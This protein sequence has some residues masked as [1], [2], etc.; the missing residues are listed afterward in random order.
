MVVMDRLLHTYLNYVRMYL[1]DL[2]QQ[3]TFLNTRTLPNIKMLTHDFSDF[4]L[5][6]RYLKAQKMDGNYLLEL[7][8]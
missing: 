7:S 3:I 6:F 5:E 4:S 1:T 2:T 8:G